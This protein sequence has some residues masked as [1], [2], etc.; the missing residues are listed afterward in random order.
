MI[1]TEPIAHIRLDT[2]GVAWIDDTNVK[3]IEVALEK[4]AHDCS[5]EQIVKEHPHLTLG[6]IYAALSYYYDHQRKFDAQMRKDLQEVEQ[7]RKAAGPPPKFARLR[8][9]KNRP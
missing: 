7:L 2:D 8:E 4:L 6:Q 3:V 1:A 5:A 9:V